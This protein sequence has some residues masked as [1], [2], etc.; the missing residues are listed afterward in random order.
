M[1]GEN[2]STGTDRL[3]NLAQ[4]GDKDALDAL[5]DGHR[6]YLRRV[7]E[8]RM[9]DGLRKRVDASDVVQETQ[10]AAAGRIGHYLANRSVSFRI[11]LRQTAIQQL[12]NLQR[13]HV[14]AQ[15]RSVNRD[16]CLSD[17]SSMLLA[18]RLL[19]A[20]PSQIVRR[21][22]QAQQVRDAVRSM[23]ETDREILLLRH[24]EELTNN[25]ISELLDIDSGTIRKRYGRA[26]RRFREKLQEQGISRSS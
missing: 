14:Q 13:R 17:H 9:E 6:D 8:L 7:I 2:Q 23:G 10:L 24:F 19:E 12:V 25:E 3:L 5:L 26:I 11:W 20:R 22:E 21:H 1:T 15:K 16:A 4:A 18:Q